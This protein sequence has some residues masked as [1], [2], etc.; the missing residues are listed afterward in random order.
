M[1]YTVWSR[2][3]LLGESELA[4]R[5]TLPG[6]L[7]GDFVPTP[8]GESLMSIIDGV[9][10]A[11]RTLYD[12]EKNDLQAHPDADYRDGSP[13]R[14][15]RTT[16]Y[17]DAVSINDELESLDL[18]LRDPDGAV[19]QTDWISIKD[20]ERLIA[21]GS[22]LG[23]EDEDIELTEEEQR[24]VDEM[25]AEFE[26]MPW[27][28]DPESWQRELPKEFPRYQILVGLAGFERW[29]EREAAGNQE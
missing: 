6:M 2:G 12:V 20:V 18:Q 10:P 7:G 27:E 5:R 15:R 11:L 21:L 8:L 14:V 3:R 24:E 17:A 19:V 9:G 25:I 23:A 13:A 4:Y 22:E 28:D 26:A 29:M 1:P 16:E